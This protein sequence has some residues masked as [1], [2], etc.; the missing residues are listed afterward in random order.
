M[1]SPQNVRFSKVWDFQNVR[2][3]KCA[4]FTKIAHFDENRT[5]NV[6]FSQ[7]CAI[8]TIIPYWLIHSVSKKFQIAITC[9]LLIPH[10]SWNL[11]NNTCNP[12]LE[13]WYLG[14]TPVYGTLS[15]KIDEIVDSSQILDEIFG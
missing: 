12:I 11:Q 2:F 1:I 14:Y 9:T 6:R 7:K 13:T 3:S 8:F 15:L 10:A 4:I 5:K